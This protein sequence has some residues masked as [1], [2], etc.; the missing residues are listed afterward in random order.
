M[1]HSVQEQR[2]YFVYGLQV[3]DSGMTKQGNKVNEE[4]FSLVSLVHCN[5]HKLPQSNFEVAPF[6]AGEVCFNN[7]S[8]L[9]PTITVAGW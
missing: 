9:C 3:L 8:G 6:V 4:K 5:K 2:L 7:L 1:T